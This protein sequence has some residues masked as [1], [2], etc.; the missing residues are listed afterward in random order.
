MAATLAG[1]SRRSSYAEYL[2]LPD[3]LR[4]EYVN[5][6]VLVN[7][8]PSFSHQRTCQRLCRLLAATVPPD[9]VA[10]AVG[11]EPVVQLTRDAPTGSV[12]IAGFGVIQLSLGDLLDG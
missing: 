1:L 4:A 11:W 12:S 7:P 9:L 10:V 3:D 2:A 6:E 8:P 5:G